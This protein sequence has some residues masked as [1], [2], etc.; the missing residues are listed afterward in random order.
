MVTLQLV[1]RQKGN[2]RQGLEDRLF[3]CA[4]LCQAFAYNFKL[5]RQ[6]WQW[7]EEC[8]YRSMGA[9]V[10]VASERFSA[11]KIF[12]LRSGDEEEQGLERLEGGLSVTQSRE[13][14]GGLRQWQAM[15]MVRGG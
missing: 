14:T 10:S 3:V 4:V 9:S 6:S 11:E 2:H 12:E 13:D 15:Q 1:C 8:T 7:K 5:Q